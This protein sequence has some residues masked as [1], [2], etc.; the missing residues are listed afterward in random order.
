MLKPVKT[1]NMAHRI[2]IV[3]FESLKS[4]GVAK[5]IS[6]GVLYHVSVASITSSMRRWKKSV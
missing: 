4:R 5:M 6:R 3:K 1:S 2:A